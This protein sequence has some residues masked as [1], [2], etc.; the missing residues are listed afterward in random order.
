M[1]SENQDTAKKSKTGNYDYNLCARELLTPLSKKCA[2]LTQNEF[3][4]KVNSYANP[5]TTR[6]DYKKRRKNRNFSHLPVPMMRT[7]SLS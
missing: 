6:P 7:F 2:R 5:T 1:P 4:K 3:E